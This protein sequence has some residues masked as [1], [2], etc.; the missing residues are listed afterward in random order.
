MKVLSS[1]LSKLAINAMPKQSDNYVLNNR[2]TDIKETMGS[3]C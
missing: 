3:E 2:N 1:K